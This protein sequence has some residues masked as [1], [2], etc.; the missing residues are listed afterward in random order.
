MQTNTWQL[1]VT[2]QR[3]VV[4]EQPI[5]PI[6]SVKNPKAVGF[7]TLRMGPTDCSETSVRNYHYSLRNNPEER[8]SLLLRG[9]S[10]QQAQTIPF[11]YSSHTC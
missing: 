4:W 11:I 3:V 5:G 2:T 9:G 6:L 7:L 8:S 1:W 10:L